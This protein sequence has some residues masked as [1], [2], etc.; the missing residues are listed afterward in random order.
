MSIENDPKR[1][2][3]TSQRQKIWTNAKGKC[4]KC[5]CELVD[6]NWR[7]H[8]ITHHS[9]GDQTK[10]DNGEALCIPCYKFKHRDYIDRQNFSNFTKDYSW[11]DEAISKFFD[12][13]NL[14]YR[15]SKDDALNQAYVVEVSPSGGKTIFSMKLAKE[16]INRDLID[17]I[18]WVVPRDSIKMGF[19]DD[20]KKAGEVIA[21]KQ[22]VIGKKYLAI[23]VKTH[24]SKLGNMGNHHGVVLTYQTLAKSP[25]TL[26]QI[27]LLSKKHRLLFVFDEAHH[28]A[29]GPDKA[30]NMWGKNMLDIQQMCHSIVAMTGTPVRSDSHKIPFL[31]YT[32]IEEEYNGNIKKAL[33]VEPSYRFTY[34]QAVEA[35]V[36]RR[37]L[38]TNYDPDITYSVDGDLVV[39]RL[40]TIPYSEFHKVK[41][42]ALDQGESVID[43]LLKK[44]NEE[45]DRMIRN[46]DSD[47]ACLVIGRR[48]SLT[49]V[50]AL[51]HISARISNLLN[52]SAVTVESVDG[53]R[54]R[55]AIKAFKR[56]REK[57]IVSKEMISE[58]TNIPRIRVICILRDIGNK[59]FYEQLVHR[60]SRNDADDR[61]EDAI[62]IQL[63]YSN[64]VEWGKELEEDSNLIWLPDED[65]GSG[66]GTIDGDPATS[67][68]V[69]GIEATLDD[70]VVDVIISGEDYSDV[71]PITVKLMDNN[72]EISKSGMTRAQGDIFL[73]AIQDSGV[74][75]SQITNIN[76]DS[77]NDGL[78]DYKKLAKTL[79]KRVTQ[80]TNKRL[81]ERKLPY[82]S[83]GKITTDIWVEVKRACN[84][85]LDMELAEIEG[86]HLNP[87][88]AFNDML[89]YVISSL[90]STK[91]SSKQGDL[92][93]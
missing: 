79:N 85:P 13:I 16:M 40:S 51:G 90:L 80:A 37:I 89:N 58:G 46:G 7:A 67:P 61:P 55:T 39:K 84:V 10:V 33:R 49:S 56:G 76:L 57:F 53:E 28:G 54:A 27:E 24:I 72:I 44:A 43:K 17:R 34:R 38:C 4:Q 14:Y 5:G 29:D 31:E 1:K 93:L 11:Q 47:A 81:R 82:S 21:E 32:E 48:E 23:G 86:Q 25:T 75:V 42:L 35:G 87:E 19:A 52:I 66:S 15:K 73:K 59:T 65:D 50:D 88:K 36:A 62:I 92:N 3:T 78:V 30:M 26:E 18:I 71:D 41:Y 20:F 68:E 9:D 22:T 12:G 74:D 64:L 6:N 83:Y 8:H 91:N 60:A 77:T 2:F 45:V 69:I 70:D 63:C